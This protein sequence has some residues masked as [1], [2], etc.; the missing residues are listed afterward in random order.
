MAEHG[1]RKR[2]RSPISWRPPAEREDEF[3]ARV[4]A[5]GLSVNAF[6]TEAVFGRSRH[7]P[8]ETKLLA[9]LLASSAE[10]AED[11]RELRLTGAEAGNTLLLEAI[12]D[13]LI[14]IRSALFTLMGRKP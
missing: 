6:I 3:D 14:E 1:N 11:S 7:R 10:I 2:R 12:H 5:S 4:A 9:R 13:R 8:A